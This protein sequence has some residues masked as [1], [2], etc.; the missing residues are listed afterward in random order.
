MNTKKTVYII[1]KEG[2]W[3][4][5]ICDL[6]TYGGIFLLFMINEK[7]LGGSWVIEVFTLVI[8]VGL[9]TNFMKKQPTFKTKEEAIN[10]LK[11]LK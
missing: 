9:V 6:F 2:F 10:H 1:I 5:I 4:S 3:G 7:Y 11:N 8:L